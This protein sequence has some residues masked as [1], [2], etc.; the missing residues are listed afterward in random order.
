MER[1]TTSFQ[2]P[3]SNQT[4]VIKTYLTGREKRALTNVF[5]SGGIDFNAETQDVKNL[6]VS[7]VDK[8]EDLA[9]KT[10]IVSIDGKKDGEIDIVNT[11]LDM[12][13]EDFDCVVAKV[14]DLI[15][16]KKFA[17]KKTI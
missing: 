17:E 10:I 16:V 14:N 2:T 1:E 4:I 7:K 8:H 3:I 12:R 13:S 11:I 5:I 15:S 6:D 9:W